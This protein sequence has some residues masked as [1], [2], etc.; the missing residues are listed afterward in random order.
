MN[1][2]LDSLKSSH[3]LNPVFYEGSENVFRLEFRP[4]DK[5]IGKPKPISNIIVL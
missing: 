5:Y 2:F 3:L 4:E 1:D